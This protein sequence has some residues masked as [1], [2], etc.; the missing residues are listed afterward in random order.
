[1]LSRGGPAQVARCAFMVA[2][3]LPALISS[4]VLAGQAIVRD[5]FV[6]AFAPAYPD[7]RGTALQLAMRQAVA[8]AT[9][10]D[11]VTVQR[12]ESMVSFVEVLEETVRPEYYALRVSIGV[13][14]PNVR[15]VEVPVELAEGPP[16]VVHSPSRVQDGVPAQ[17]WTAPGGTTPTLLSLKVPRGI[18]GALAGY[19][20][21]LAGLDVRHVRI[22]P[23][24]D[25][26][27]DVTVSLRRPPAHLPEPPAG[28]GMLISQA[29]PSE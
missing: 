8:K 18:P 13:R 2:A 5:I 7:A 11:S 1:M 28:S 3:A 14:G 29:F 26:L 23:N 4:P 16:P 24:P 22:H 9:G 27:L 12:A 17:P 21:V 20:A 19:R 10:T 6:E 25:L 15:E